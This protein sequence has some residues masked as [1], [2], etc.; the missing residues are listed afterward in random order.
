MPAKKRIPAQ[1]T[2]A[3]SPKRRLILTLLG[4]V[5]A[6][7]GLAATVENRLASPDI[8]LL[9]A[10]HGGRWIRQNRPFKL[11]GW[12]PT[13]EVV[14][15]RKRVTVP[16]GTKAC[17]VTVQ[18]LRACVVY[19]DKRQLA[20]VKPEDWKQPHEVVLNDLAPGEHE[21]EVFVEDSLGPAALLV[22]ADG[23]DLRT[24]PGWEESVY[25]EEWLPAAL[26]DD[27][28]P[29]P[30]AQAFPSPLRALASSL[31]WLG[32]LFAGL[33][34][35]LVWS[36]RSDG[37]FRLPN[38]WTP[39]RSRWVVIAAWII[40][41]ANNFLKLPAQMGYD[42]PS[43]VDYIRFIAERGELPD[44]S[45]GLQMFQTPLFYALAA[46][47]YR[48][49]TLFLAS[50]T[51]LLWLRWLTLLCGIA[52][53]EICYRAGRIV[54]PERDE[55]QSLAVFVGGLLPMNVYISQT[56]GNEPL[57]GL[58]SALILLWGWRTL[59]APDPATAGRQWS[60]GVLFGLDLLSK[61]T[62]LLLTP[63][64]AGVLVVANR[65]R[66]L[67]GVLQAFARTFG[68]ATV[69]AGWY[70]ARN[71]IHFGKPLV[72]G[73]DPARGIPWWQD[74]G[75]R[76][77]WQMISF[78]RSL[79]T[80]LHAGFYSLA[81]GFFASLW[82]D[83]NFSGMDAP[84]PWNM[85]L[86]LAAPWPALLLTAAIAAGLARAIFCR[87]KTLRHSLQLAGVTLFLY[88]GAFVLLWLEVPAFSQAKASY[89]LGL[90]PA[91]AVLCVAGL[92][93]LPSHRMAR[94]AVFAFVLSWSVLVYGAYFVV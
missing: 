51:A 64:I 19:W 67:G 1:E 45:D 46:V 15:F 76:T 35:C 9:V 62:A 91:Y 42:L 14:F 3:G 86:M 26:A 32:P 22:Y 7:G 10:S 40:L 75:Y 78:G 48:G 36:T 8:K 2:K 73:W 77:P 44:A 17:T 89:T 56:L 30:L 59:R 87:D 31:W 63:V 82:W 68:T 53:V 6:V 88:L 81:D 27:A 61:M 12:G 20:A 24:G 33:W 70:Y 52:Q 60:G 21:F 72:G 74:P 5:V 54:F 80:P 41:A 13:Q 94:A 85:R 11:T 84:P 34:A 69:V 38:W 65:L 50:S 92:D 93:L 39:S 23:L 4:I 79:F 43:H 18:A 47:V 66:G 58:F 16:A 28:A 83:G 29:P 37:V 49:L 71:W 57:C 25:G 90:T 55:L